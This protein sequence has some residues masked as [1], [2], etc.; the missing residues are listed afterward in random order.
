MPKW[1][2]VYKSTVMT[3]AMIYKEAVTYLLAAYQMGG[4]DADTLYFLARSYQRSGDE[5]N[6]R[7][8]FQMLVRQY[9][10][11]ERAD[12]AHQCMDGLE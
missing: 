3:T 6:A 4:T 2:N 1:Q 7:E 12:M 9:P 5:E 11:S 8:Y 10:N